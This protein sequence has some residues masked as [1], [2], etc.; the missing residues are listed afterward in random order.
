MDSLLRANTL[1]LQEHVDIVRRER[2]TAQLLAEQLRLA[3]RH[4]LPDDVWRYDQMIGKAEK[5]EQYF[6]GMADQ[7]EHM[8]FELAQ[9]SL[10]INRMLSEAGNQLERRNM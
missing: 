1:R 8:S 9:L 5:L 3:R 6:R 4:A 2:R 10:E 7:V